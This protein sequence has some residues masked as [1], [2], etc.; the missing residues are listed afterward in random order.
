M[1]DMLHEPKAGPLGGCEGMLIT[2][3]RHVV[4]LIRLHLIEVFSITLAGSS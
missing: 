1:R 2:D 4:M 3:S